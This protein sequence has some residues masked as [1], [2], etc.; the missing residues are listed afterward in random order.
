MAFLYFLF[1]L[2]A[3]SISINE[4]GKFT[5][6]IFDLGDSASYKSEI[7]S[8][9]LTINIKNIPLKYLPLKN[10]SGVLKFKL[11]KRSSTN[12]DL[13]I[14]L[15]AVKNLEY[16]FVAFYQKESKRYTVDFWLIDN[17][18][19]IIDEVPKT[20]TIKSSKKIKKLPRKLKV[21]SL[22]KKK[23]KLTISDEELKLPELLPVNYSFSDP[24]VL[25]YKLENV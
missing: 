7:N 11:E 15:K 21:K 13:K 6:V 23:K 5:R 14:F 18:I 10:Y 8:N 1:C 22:R 17:K 16:D 9:T 24:E 19:K 2:Y 12:Y 25:R 3:S 20:I 4:N